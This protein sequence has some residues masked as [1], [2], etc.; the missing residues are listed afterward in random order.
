MNY[1][2]LLCSCQ[3]SDLPKTAKVT[4]VLN[5]SLHT[6]FSR[7]KY[8]LEFTDERKHGLHDMR[9]VTENVN[10]TVNR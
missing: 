10:S 4:N 3:T 9:T 8:M 5:I 2:G 7:R 1:L 6:Y